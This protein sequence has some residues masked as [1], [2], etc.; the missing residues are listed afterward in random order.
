MKPKIQ[1]AYEVKEKMDKASSMCSDDRTLWIALGEWC[2]AV[3]GL[4]KLE[5]SFASVFFATPPTS[6]FDEAIGYYTKANDIRTDHRVLNLLG[7]CHMGKKEWARPRHTSNNP[8]EC[9]LQ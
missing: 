3:A 1:S 2:R 5:R 7:D 4:S 8:S 9:R 6:T